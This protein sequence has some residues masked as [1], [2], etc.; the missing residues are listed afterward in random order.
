MEFLVRGI[1]QHNEPGVFIC[2][3]ERAAD[4]AANVASLGFDL[5]AL[6]E[7]KKLFTRPCGDR[8]LR[9]DGDRRIRP[10][11]SVHAAGRSDR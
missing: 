6:I 10:R 3:E 11:R 9:D 5:A 8:P 4:L 2:F 1:Q 7:D